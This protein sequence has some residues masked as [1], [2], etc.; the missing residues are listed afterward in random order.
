MIGGRGNEPKT[1]GKGFR[2]R[3]AR[4][5]SLVFTPEVERLEFQL[6]RVLGFDEKQRINKDV[7]EEKWR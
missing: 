5:L 4:C 1:P 6:E 3:S 7:D 2:L